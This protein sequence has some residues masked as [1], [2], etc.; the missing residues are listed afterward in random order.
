MATRITINLDEHNAQDIA[1]ILGIIKKVYVSES[2]PP[3]GRQSPEEAAVLA[4][5]IQAN[6][7][8]GTDARPAVYEPLTDDYMKGWRACSE[9]IEGQFHRMTDRAYSTYSGET[10]TVNMDKLQTDLRDPRA[11]YSVYPARMF[12]AIRRTLLDYECARVSYETALAVM[13]GFCPLFAELA[14]YLSAQVPDDT[15]PR[16]GMA[17]DV[18]EL[19][20]LYRGL[21]EFCAVLNQS[22]VGVCGAPVKPEQWQADTVRDAI[23]GFYLKPDEAATLKHIGGVLVDLKDWCH[24]ARPVFNPDRNEWIPPTHPAANVPNPFKDSDGQINT[25]AVFSAVAELR[26]LLEGGLRTVDA[27]TKKLGA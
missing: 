11:P 17:P 5:E 24:R 21:A 13:M 23:R 20:R 22:R 2:T 9:F 1:T 18:A 19:D 26:D 8:P 7:E 27:A 6:P 10:L 16:D 25:R 15:V 4:N 14:N 3:H 12:K